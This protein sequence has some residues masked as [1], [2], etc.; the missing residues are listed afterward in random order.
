MRNGNAKTDLVIAMLCLAAI[1]YAQFGGG[2]NPFSPPPVKSSLVLI[3][4]ETEA[5]TAELATILNGEALENHLQAKWKD[6]WRVLDKDADLSHVDDQWKEAM[7]AAKGHEG[8]TPPWLLVSNGKSG[9]QGPLPAENAEAV[10]A[11]LGEYEE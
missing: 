5:R 6:Q 8:F 4:E 2:G 3:V 10:I 11:K 1:V 9:W 7:A